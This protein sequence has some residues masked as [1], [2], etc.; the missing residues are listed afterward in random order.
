MSKEN[1]GRK[2]NEFLGEGTLPHNEQMESL[3]GRKTKKKG[4]MKQREK[5]VRSDK[6]IKEFRRRK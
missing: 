6:E 1:T 5:D 3:D 2:L 4:D